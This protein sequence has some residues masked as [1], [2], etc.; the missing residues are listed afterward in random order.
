MGLSILRAL[1]GKAFSS[2]KPLLAEPHSPS[3][4]RPA[5]RVTAVGVQQ[6]NSGFCTMLLSGART[7]HYEEENHLTILQRRNGFVPPG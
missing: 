5:R 1:P 3:R 4:P 7:A 6:A 2:P